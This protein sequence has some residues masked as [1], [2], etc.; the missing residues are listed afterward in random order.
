MKSFALAAGFVLLSA[1]G[2]YLSPKATDDVSTSDQRGTA[3]EAI[4]SSPVASPTAPIEDILPSAYNVNGRS[5]VK[6]YGQWRL[7]P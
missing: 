6:Q 7:M 2:Y 4:Q 1:Y 5:V 3:V